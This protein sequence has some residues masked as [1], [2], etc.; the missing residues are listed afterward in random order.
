[1]TDLTILA[2]IVE[3]LARRLNND[4]VPNV[5]ALWSKAK[6]VAGFAITDAKNEG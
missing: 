3:V 6:P 2:W 4:I 5:M 1:M